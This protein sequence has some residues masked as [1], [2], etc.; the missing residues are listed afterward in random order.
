MY[1][2]Y[3]LKSI[4]I[5]G[6]AMI[7]SIHTVA[8]NEEKYLPQLLEN[9]INQSYPLKK[10][11]LI[12]IDSLSS[13]NT[14]KIMEDFRVKYKN[15]FY[16]VKV[17]INEKI[18][19]APGQNI[20]IVNS[21]GD[22]IIKIDAHA[23]IPSNFVEMNVKCIENGED[24][25]GG[26]RTNIIDEDKVYKK[27]LLT[28]ENSMFGSGIAPYRREA[29]KKYVR[30]VAHTCYKKEV[31]DKIGIIN[32]NLGR[33]EDNEINYRVRQNGYKICMDPLI[34]SEYQTRT[35]F[36]KMLKQKYSNGYWVGLTSQLS[37]K[38]FSIYHYA[39]FVLL[40]CGLIS[41]FLFCISLFNNNIFL[42]FPLLI[43]GGMYIFLDIILSICSS[44]KSKVFLGVLVLPIMFPL[45][46]ISYGI[47]TLNGFL[48]IPFSK[49][50]F[51]KDKGDVNE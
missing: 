4:E 20:G 40:L 32:E 3:W 7:V 48:K 51:L 9:F 44:I 21:E 31:F 12:L 37:F 13:D 11:E 28:A 18:K 14:K 33:S 49:K 19:Q 25:C 8:L 30:T 45:L 43:G 10:I 22:L 24:V 42:T 27:I 17:L 16:K 1:D 2:K 15:E 47:G 38:I 26:K 6:F 46:H 23:L 34:N 39:P 29:I 5:G 36:Y 50:K 41:L 35:T